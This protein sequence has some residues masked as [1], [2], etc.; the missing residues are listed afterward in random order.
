MVPGA[1]LGLALCAASGRADWYRRAAIAGLFGAIGWAWGGTLSYMEQTLYALSGS[2]PDVLYGYTILFFFGA[3]WA[4]IGA[5]VLGLALTEPISVLETLI[6]PFAAVSAAFLFIYLIFFFRPSWADAM[7]TLSVRQFHRTVWLGS[8]IAL[9]VSGAYW[10]LRRQDRQGAALIFRCAAAWWVGYLAFTKWGG[11]RL[12]PLHRSEGW[13]GV[14]GILV[15]LILY[16]RKRQNRAALSLCLYGIWG[17]G[18]AFPLAVF[19]RHPIAIH[20]GPFQGS[21][22][23]WR[24]AEFNFGFFMGMAVA[25][26][27][28]RL[29]RGRLMPPGDDRSPS[30]LNAFSGF[31]LLIAINWMNFRHHAAPLIARSAASPAPRFLGVEPWICMVLLGA[32]ASIPPLYA[33]YRYLRGDVRFAAASPY[34]KA[35]LLTLLVVWVTLA[36]YTMQDPPGAANIAGHMLLWI[37][38]VAA[39]ILLLS[40]AGATRDSESPHDPYVAASGKQWTGPRHRILWG[41]TPALLL[42]FAS[43]SVTMKSS[44]VEGMGRKRFG[45]D[46]Y[47]RQTANLLGT[48]RAIG[49]KQDPRDAGMQTSD[50]P[51]LSLTFKED[52]SVTVALPGGRNATGYQWFLKDQYVWLRA[53]GQAASQSERKD[54]PLQ[55]QGK[56]VA[57]AWNDGRREAVLVYERAEE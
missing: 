47:W 57:I 56:Q 43:L 45:T 29:I 17:G 51:V 24:F 1:L 30:P 25:L 15:V 2:F 26:G 50:L 8:A 33:L 39:S 31:V 32:L 38:A 49:M 35:T 7:E 34:A 42:A 44:P 20:W 4:G 36:G 27:V 22:P 10:L 5:A 14:L 13:G 21:W 16:L 41:V 19:L 53:R 37:P 23:Q 54:A 3:L 28:V 6:R 11:L 40:C 9:V 18:L 52:R 55:F 12:A 46:A 48:W